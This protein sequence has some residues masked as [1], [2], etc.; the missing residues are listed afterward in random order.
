MPLMRIP[1][2]ASVHLIG[3]SRNK[4]KR[5]L[6]SRNYEANAKDLTTMED[7]DAWEMQ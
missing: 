6:K 3:L 5:L 2:V 4:H 7:D 1:S